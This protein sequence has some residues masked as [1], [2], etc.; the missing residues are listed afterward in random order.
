MKALCSR[1]YSQEYNCYILVPVDNLNAKI[2]EE[3]AAEV[4]CDLKEAGKKKRS[5][6]QN[7]AMWLYWKNLADAFND[8]GLDMKKVLN[9]EVDIPW[10][11]DLIKEHIWGKIQELLVGHTKT[12]KLE[13]KQVSEI[14]DIVNRRV[15]QNHGVNV[16]FPSYFTEQ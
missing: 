1:V 15:A 10:N 3:C 6:Q 7:N 4:I 11:E 5:L 14:Y 8:A 2:V 13:S 12:S 9:D 16:P